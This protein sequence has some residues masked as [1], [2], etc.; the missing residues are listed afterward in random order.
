VLDFLRRRN[1]DLKR[2]VLVNNR[3]VGRVWTTMEDI[4]NALKLP[5]AVTVPYVVEYMTMAINESV[6]FMAKFPEHAAGLVFT[7]LARR[8]QQY[9][10]AQK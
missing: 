5:L 1:L 4:E 6:P 7:E 8:L 2:I 10:R 9:D 3:T